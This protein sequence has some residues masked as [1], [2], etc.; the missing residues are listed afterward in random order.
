MFHS[1]SQPHQARTGP[2][3]GL[4]QLETEGCRHGGP[5]QSS[6]DG[7]A[8]TDPAEAGKVEM[9]DPGS[10]G[11]HFEALEPAAEQQGREPVTHL[12]GQGGE[13]EER[14]GDVLPVRDHV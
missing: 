6:G 2:G 10:A 1:G 12:M 3:A 4:P 11:P 13:Q 14:P 9:G 5:H 7:Q 8:L